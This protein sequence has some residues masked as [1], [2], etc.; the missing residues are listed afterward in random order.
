MYL[1]IEQI[2]EEGLALEFEEQVEIFPIL[3]EMISQGECIFIAPI[4]TAVRATRIDDMIE[5]KGEVNSQV[6]PAA[7]VCR[8][9]NCLSGPALI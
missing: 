6:C 5:V 7:V 4:K 2:N 9:M 1:R 3:S 8:S